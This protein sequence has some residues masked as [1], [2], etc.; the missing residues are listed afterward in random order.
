MAIGGRRPRR[1]PRPA[2]RDHD[3]R[4]AARVVFADAHSG[5]EHAPGLSRPSGSGAPSGSPVASG[6]S[7]VP[8][9]SP[10]GSPSASPSPSATPKPAVPVA[11]I[12]YSGLR[13]DATTGVDPV[14]RTFTFKTDGPVTVTAKLT[15]RTAGAKTKMCIQVSTGTPFCRS[16]VSGSLTGTTTSAKTTAF[17]VTLIG[18]AAATPTVDLALV[19]RA[20]APSVT[21]ANAHFDGTAADPGLNGITAKVTVRVAGNLSI[22]AAWGSNPFDYTYGLI[23]LT[24]PSAG[25]S[26]TGN[27]VGLERSDPVAAGDA[28][29]VSLAN[30]GTGSGVTPLTVTIK[31]P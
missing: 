17:T 6:A 28:Y 15:G 29:A 21:L 2:R 1:R 10:G 4:R 18:V 11:R 9:G 3:R 27:G 12:T 16:W 8:S 30:S 20:K 13:L 22:T 26:F 7:A 23:D 14:I 24:H 19:F 31:W 25:G 5:R